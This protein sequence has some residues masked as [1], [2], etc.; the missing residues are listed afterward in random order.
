[1]H[2]NTFQLKSHIIITMAMTITTQ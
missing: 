2:D 1:M